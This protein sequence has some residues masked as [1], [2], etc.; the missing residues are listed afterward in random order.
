MV[1]MI[2]ID[3]IVTTASS[4]LTGVAGWAV[5]RRRRDND[6]LTEQQKSIGMLID[7]NNTIMA[8]YTKAQSELAE[9]RTELAKATEENTRL[10]RY[11]TELQNENEKLRKKIDLL[12][13]KIEAFNS[14][15]IER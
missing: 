7:N 6:F 2:P 1:E 4:I 8:K 14:S 15:K 3:M 12:S 9:A 5:G 10:E 13:K 11:V